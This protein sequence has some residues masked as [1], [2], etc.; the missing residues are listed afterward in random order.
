[1]D[2]IPAPR[3]TPPEAV[4]VVEV[5]IKI[6][7]LKRG[8]VFGYEII[9]AA[10]RVCCWTTMD[11]LLLRSPLHAWRMAIKRIRNQRMSAPELA[12]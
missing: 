7:V 5:P 9:M 10:D 8:A 6:K 3:R 12:E 4:I 11:G 1:M 2:S